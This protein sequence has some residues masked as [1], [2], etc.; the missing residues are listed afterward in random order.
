MSYHN[1][2]EDEAEAYYRTQRPKMPLL[3]PGVL[4]RQFA[5]NGSRYFQKCFALE[6]TRALLVEKGRAEQESL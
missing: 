2:T 4:Q 1:K 6:L 5:G 3:L